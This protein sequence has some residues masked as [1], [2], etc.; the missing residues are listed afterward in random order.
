MTCITKGCGSSSKIWLNETNLDII[1]WILPVPTCSTHPKNVLEKYDASKPFT[2]EI[3][4]ARVEIKNRIKAGVSVTKALD[5]VI[6]QAP[7]TL[8]QHISRGTLYKTAYQFYWRNM[9][10][11]SLLDPPLNV[12]NVFD[13]WRSLLT[14]PRNDEFKYA[15]RHESESPS[16]ILCNRQIDQNFIICQTAEQRDILFYSSS[17][18]IDQNE[19]VKPKHSCRT[20]TLMGCYKGFE[21]INV[22]E[23]LM[24]DKKK[25]SHLQVAA[26]LRLLLEEQFEN[27]EFCFE[28]NM[29]VLELIFNFVSIHDFA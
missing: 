1:Q 9:K 15:H 25:E 27:M 21:Y 8:F 24:R 13:Q 22:A 5:D 12:N 2:Q 26:R 14:N 10:I 18:A 7:A 20:L 4:A 16:F 23:I 17:L 6:I 19:R 11:E 3:Q 28:G 29:L